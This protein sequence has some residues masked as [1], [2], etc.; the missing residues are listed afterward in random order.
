[1]FHWELEAGMKGELARLG[2]DHS[3][4]LTLNPLLS[5]ER[6]ENRTALLTSLDRLRRESDSTGTM[7]AMDAMDSFT[8]QAVGILMSGDL[9]RVLDLNAEDPQILQRYMA[10]TAA[11]GRQ[12]TTSEGPKSI[13]S[14]QKICPI[15]TACLRMVP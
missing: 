3:V 10:P 11:N 2:K 13:R 5:P 4:S 9:A 8:Q 6:V 14:N 1:M 12:S 7:D 15:S